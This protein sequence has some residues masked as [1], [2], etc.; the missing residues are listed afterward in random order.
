M[1]INECLSNR[2]VADLLFTL[3]RAAGVNIN[4]DM[5]FYELGILT[6]AVGSH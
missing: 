6:H 3:V 1:K 5:S 4:V 2:T